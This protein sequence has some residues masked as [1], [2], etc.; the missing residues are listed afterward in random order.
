M[1]HNYVLHAMGIKSGLRFR[2]RA[3]NH[4]YNASVP[5]RKLVISGKGNFLENIAHQSELKMETKPHRPKMTP[6]KFN[7]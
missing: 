3:M 6:M 2:K 5:V 4:F 1:A 7:F